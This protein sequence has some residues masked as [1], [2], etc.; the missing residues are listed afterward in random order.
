MVEI[1]YILHLNPWTDMIN[2]F[3]RP[4]IMIFYINAMIEFSK[5]IEGKQFV[6]SSPVVSF[7]LSAGLSILLLWSWRWRQ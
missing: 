6:D 1:S 4:Y 3:F 5:H 7:T 2:N